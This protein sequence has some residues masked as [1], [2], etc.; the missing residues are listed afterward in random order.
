MGVAGSLFL[1]CRSKKELQSFI[2][3]EFSWKA[4]T[5]EG[6]SPVSEK[7][8]PLYSSPKYYGTREIP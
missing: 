5:K 3:A 4:D 1:I 6:E 2:L 7:I 8:K